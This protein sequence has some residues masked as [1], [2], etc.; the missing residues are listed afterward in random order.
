MENMLTPLD[1]SPVVDLPQRHWEGDMLISS[2][3]FLKSEN[4]HLSHSTITF[5]NVE[6][7]Y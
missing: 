3:A 6:Q 7:L 1:L 2:I 5:V 4:R